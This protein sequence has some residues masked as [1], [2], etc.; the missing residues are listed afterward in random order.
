MRWLLISLA[1]GLLMTIASAVTSVSHALPDTMLAWLSA[2]ARFAIS[3]VESRRR[4]AVPM[5]SRTEMVVAV[6]ATMA[7]WSGI[8]YLTLM[9]AS[10]LRGARENGR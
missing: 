7:V 4:G 2:P 3:L 8:S 1:V 10:R 9:L 6:A 5:P